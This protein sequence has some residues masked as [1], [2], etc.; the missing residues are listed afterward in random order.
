M[1]ESPLDN[2]QRRQLWIRRLAAAWILGSICLVIANAQE[3]RRSESDE[4]QRAPA[5]AATSSAWTDLLREATWEQQWRKTNYGGE[6]EIRL[7]DGQLILETGDPL[8]GVTWT[9]DFPQDDYEIRWSAARLE[10]N[11]FFSCLTFPVGEESCSI[12]VGGWGGG[13]VGLST[14]DGSDASENETTD[15]RDFENDRFYNFRLLVT[16]QTIQFFIDDAPMID[17]P[18]EGHR[19]GVRIE[20][21]RNKPLG[22]AAFQCRAAIKDFRY[23]RLTHDGIKAQPTDASTMLSTNAFAKFVRLAEDDNG[24]PEALQTAV[25]T[26]EVTQGKH[27]GATIEL[28]GAVHVGQPEYYRELNKLFATYDALLFELVADPS[29]RLPDRQDSEGVINPISS[30]QVAMKDSLELEFQLDEI[31]YLAKNFVHADMTPAEFLENM[32]S[33]NDDFVSMFARVLGSAI[34]AQATQ[35][36]RDAE[37]MAA[38][39]SSN[40]TRDLRRVLAKQLTQA[41]VEMMG[42]QDDDGKSTLVTERNNKA[43]AVLKQRLE[44]GDRRIGIFYGAAHLDDMHLKLQDE[45]NAELQNVRWLE[46]WDLR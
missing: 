14:I 6:G 20:V 2:R 46:A 28:V 1:T 30:L 12:V 42:L 23:R 35:G 11:D 31:D 27:K 43:L 13:V 41:T 39:L 7:D 29:I 17:L 24:R 4:P 33:R 22:M 9:E 44:Q 36:N 37:L 45:F 18:R 21:E 5:G 38:L 26:Y 32:R 15:Y 19:F 25:A 8:T 16:K 34:A 3:G 40:R 10:G